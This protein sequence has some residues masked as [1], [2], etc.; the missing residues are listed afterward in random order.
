MLEVAPVR[1]EGNTTTQFIVT[2]WL[3]GAE[4]VEIRV[5]GAPV[6]D[7]AVGP[8]PDIVGLPDGTVGFEAEIDVPVG[9]H[10]VC[11]TVAG[12]EPGVRGCQTVSSGTLLPHNRVV[13]YYG[14]PRSEIL[15]TL[16]V[17]TPDEA[18][19]RL[20]ADTALFDQPDRPAMP[21]FELIVTAAQ[22]QPGNGTYSAAISKED[23]QRYLDAVRAVDG[24]LIMDFQPGRAEYMDQLPFF[25]E[26]LIQPD[27]HVGL[28]PEWEMLPNQVP[29]SNVGQTDGT[30]I[31]T[32]MNYLEQLVIEHDLPPKLVVVHQFNQEMISSRPVIEPPTHVQLVM[33]MDGFGTPEDK[34]NNYQNLAVR[35]PLF[36]GFK[37]FAAEDNPPTT[38]AD[39]LQLAP[40]ADV[41]TY[42]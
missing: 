40:V 12:A 29:G 13:A 28:D 22:T 8:G 16:G 42:Q 19:A 34:R 25:E 17:G 37:L 35:D 38:P 7:V 10:S 24:I 9:R 21:A 14:S 4:A 23:V 11:A 5:G 1:T 33:H 41:V 30:T 18:A 39:V 20:L 3:V 26:F 36:N 6:T 32:V 2:G 31:N 27:V 15:G